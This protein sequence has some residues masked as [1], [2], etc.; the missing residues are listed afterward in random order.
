[1]AGNAVLAW[2]CTVCV[3]LAAAATASGPEQ[4]HIS[5]GYEPSQMIVVWSTAE[6]GDSV[7]SYGTDQFHLTDK[8]NGSCWRFTYGNPNGLQ[9]IHRVLLEVGNAHSCLCSY[10]CLH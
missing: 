10:S 8:N 9:Y 6:F 5:F 4:V 2:L 1:M 3:Y 7:V